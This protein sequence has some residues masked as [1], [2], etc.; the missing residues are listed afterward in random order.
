MREDFWFNF[1]CIILC[2]SML[3]YMM[4]AI[5][6]KVNKS[7]EVETQKDIYVNLNVVESVAVVE[8]HLYA[9]VYYENSSQCIHFKDKEEMSKFLKEVASTSIKIKGYND[10]RSFHSKSN[11]GAT[12]FIVVT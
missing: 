5:D 8:G 4:F 2:I 6:Y 11:G 7:E 12:P 1:I 10:N 9:V 3:A